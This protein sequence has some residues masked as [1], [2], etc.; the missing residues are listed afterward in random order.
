LNGVLCNLDL[1]NQT[2]EASFYISTVAFNLAHWFFAF[3]YLVLSYRIELLTNELPEDIHN[4]R[5]NV[6]N[7]VVCL[8]NVAIPAIAWIYDIKEEYKVSDAA[9]DIE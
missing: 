2:V 3:S 8:F 7:I 6:V 4:C 5:L 1:A 9:F